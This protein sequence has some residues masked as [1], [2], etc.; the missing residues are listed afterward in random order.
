MCASNGCVT[1]MPQHRHI[2]VQPRS[3]N[4]NIW[5]KTVFV[6]R[7]CF[8]PIFCLKTRFVPE[9]VFHMFGRRRRP[10]SGPKGSHLA[11]T[12]C[13]ETEPSD[14]VLGLFGLPC[15][16][17]SVDFHRIARGP[18]VALSRAVRPTQ[19]AHT[20]THPPTV[21]KYRWDLRICF[22]TKAT[23]AAPRRP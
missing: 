4:K 21:G 8:K 22:S 2:C 6:K 7:P 11:D 3:S 17:C 18:R 12:F 13:N 10:P 1:C 20:P 5:F 19:S 15:H 16:G 23:H 9:L 14:P